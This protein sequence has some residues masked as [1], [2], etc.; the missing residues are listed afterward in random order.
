[1]EEREEEREGGRRRG[2]G[3]CGASSRGLRLWTLDSTCSPRHTSETATHAPRT[4]RW[5]ETGDRDPKLQV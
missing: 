4:K 3:R 2:V 1:M 5:M